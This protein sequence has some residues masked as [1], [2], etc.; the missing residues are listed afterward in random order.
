MVRRSGVWC[1]LTIAIEVTLGWR[2]LMGSR[3]HGGMGSALVSVEIAKE[4]S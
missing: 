2:S 3:G 1:I 4:V